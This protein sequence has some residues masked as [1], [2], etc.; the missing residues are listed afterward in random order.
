MKKIYL[1]S[2]VLLISTKLWATTQDY[3][4]SIFELMAEKN[5][6]MHILNSDGSSKK[7]SSEF[8]DIKKFLITA[9]GNMLSG[10]EDVSDSTVSDMDMNCQSLVTPSK[11]TECLLS[12][13]NLEKRTTLYKFTARLDSQ[14]KAVEILNNRLSVSK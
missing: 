9:I 11:A 12:V 7:F 13:T 10:D 2:A 5:S 3:N 8:E 4:Q 6:Q 1:V 14:N